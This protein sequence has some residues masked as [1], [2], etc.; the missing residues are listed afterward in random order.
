MSLKKF[1]FSYVIIMDSLNVSPSVETHLNSINM[2]CNSI[3][4]SLSSAL[5]VSG[6]SVGEF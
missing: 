5:E 4:E 3:M 1:L 6:E 2:I